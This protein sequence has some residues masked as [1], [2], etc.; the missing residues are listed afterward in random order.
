MAKARRP[1]TFVELLFMKI[2]KKWRRCRLRDAIVLLIKQRTRCS[3]AML[4]STLQQETR[5]H[6]VLGYRYFFWSDPHD[7]RV[8]HHRTRRFVLA[9]RFPLATAVKSI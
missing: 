4:I 3:K 8:T 6:F 5:M 7:V 1:D 9:T 2:R